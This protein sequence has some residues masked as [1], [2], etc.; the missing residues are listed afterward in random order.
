M[1]AQ[2]EGLGWKNLSASTEAYDTPWKLSVR[3]M[4]THL[5][6]LFA[7]VA[8]RPFWCDLRYER[9]QKLMVASVF[10]PMTI[11]YIESSMRQRCKF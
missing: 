2:S 1:E 4:R 9:V 7:R 8:S 3:P 10:T 6:I 5:S 11:I